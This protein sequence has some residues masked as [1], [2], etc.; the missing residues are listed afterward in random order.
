MKFS[1]LFY[2]ILFYYIL[3]YSILFYSTMGLSSIDV[4]PLLRKRRGYGGCHGYLVK[5]R[6]LLREAVA[7]MRFSGYLA[8]N[9]VLTT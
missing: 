3:F 8:Y 2:S 6:A 4:G 7:S 5:G 9:I 1:I